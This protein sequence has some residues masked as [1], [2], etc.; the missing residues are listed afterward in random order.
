MECNA[1]S[2]KIRNIREQYYGQSELMRLLKRMRYDVFRHN[3]F[4]TTN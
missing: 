2:R 1:Y 3:E 4:L